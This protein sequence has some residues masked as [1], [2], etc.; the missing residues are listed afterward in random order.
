MGLARFALAM[1][2]MSLA[3]CGVDRSNGTTTGVEAGNAVAS[4]VVRTDGSAVVGALVVARPS[5]ALSDSVFDSART[6]SEGRFR[7]GISGG[8]WTLVSEAE[9]KASMLTLPQ[10]VGPGE[11][12]LVLRASSS[13][14]GRIQPGMVGRKIAILGSGKSAVVDSSGMFSIPVAPSGDLWLGDGTRVWTLVAAP[15]EVVAANLDTVRPGALLADHGDPLLWVWGLSPSLEPGTLVALDL[16]ASGLSGLDWSR[17]GIVDGGS[18]HPVAWD[19]ARARVWLRL[20]AG[21]AGL[22]AEL[23]TGSGA[24]I[25]AF[26]S[27]SVSDVWLFNSSSVGRPALGLIRRTEA[28]ASSAAHFERNPMD[29]TDLGIA[30]DSGSDLLQVDTNLFADSFGAVAV[31]ARRMDSRVGFSWILRLDD[32]SRVLQ[33]GLGW[34]GD[35][36]VL[37]VRGG[38]RASIRLPTLSGQRSFVVARSSS[39]W[40]V[41]H[42]GQEV[43]SVPVGGGA[44]PVPRLTVGCGGG[45]VLS[46]LLVWKTPLSEAQQDAASGRAKAQYQRPIP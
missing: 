22:R 42:G 1:A 19:S 18:M 6:D 28:M 45:L 37:E 23:S 2:A 26:D 40:R 8:G 34:N 20:A 15:A 25:G 12:L 41:S 38:A 39:R 9:G 7:L 43:L 32:S 27:A 33:A 36:L 16:K 46:E 24:S 17:L 14:S 5:R 13:I 21:G 35:T 10:G 44:A 3:C 29:A 31:R 11:R 30:T 4:R